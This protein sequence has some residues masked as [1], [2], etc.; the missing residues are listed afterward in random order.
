MVDAAGNAAWDLERLNSGGGQYPSASPTPPVP[1]TGPFIGRAVALTDFQPS[2]YDVDLLKFNKGDVIDIISKS[3]SGQWRGCVGGRVGEFKFI[4]VEEE[5]ERDRLHR[6]LR[7]QRSSPLEQFPHASVEALL[8]HFKLNHLLQMFMLH[9]YETLDQFREV[10]E[11]D[12]D[13][14]G[15]RD[16]DTR[17]KLLAAV[18]SI[19]EYEQN[20]IVGH[21]SE[22]SVTNN[23][24][25]SSRD[26]GCFTD[27]KAVSACLVP[28][29]EGSHTEGRQSSPS[30]DNSSGYQGRGNYII[31]HA[32]E[33]SSTLQEVPDTTLDS[34]S[35]TE[36]DLTSK[37]SEQ[38]A[39]TSHS[40]QRKDLD[41]RSSETGEPDSY[42][43]TPA[44][45]RPGTPD[46]SPQLRRK[47]QD[48]DDDDVLASAR[49]SSDTGVSVQSSSS[50]A[51]QSQHGNG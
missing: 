17:E 26:S 7:G 16:P 22:A 10:D 31:T 15:I 51:V 5:T 14:L 1:Y 32:G 42:R 37:E 29:S 13:N 47:L 43:A 2:P 20:S 28:D 39:P 38:P 49:C 36:E 21:V 6:R 44:L 12:L 8:R 18:A 41:I 23:T 30:T 4:L 3:P 35:S 25:S 33:V 45:V 11:Q 34:S 9:G 40:Q 48:D 27:Q 46:T 19:L 50:E 24:S